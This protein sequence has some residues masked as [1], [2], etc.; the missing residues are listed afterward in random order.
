[1][2]A[3]LPPAVANAMMAAW[4]MVVRDEA[5]RGRAAVDAA[6]ACIQ[7]LE[8]QVESSRTE[9]EQRLAAAN[10]AHERR[11]VELQEAM[12]AQEQAFRAEIDK[13][14]ERLEG[15]QKHVML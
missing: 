13:A 3:A 5:A 11:L 7:A 2:S 14:T 9:A 8:Q 15:V 1:M 6:H 4:A 10:T 12:M